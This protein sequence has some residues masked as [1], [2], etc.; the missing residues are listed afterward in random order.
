MMKFKLAF[1]SILFSILIITSACTVDNT[2]KKEIKYFPDVEDVAKEHAKSF[3]DLP[4]EGMK[5]QKKL[6]EVRA[7]EQDLR[8]AGLNDEADYYIKMFV[9]HLKN[10]NPSLADSISQK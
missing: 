6:F 7:H 10:S 1:T 4:S 5:T 2:Q 9:K 3:A 8:N